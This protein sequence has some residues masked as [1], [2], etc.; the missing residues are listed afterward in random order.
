[1]EVLQ[2]N[3]APVFTS[4]APSDARIRE[5][6]R[7]EYQALALDLDGDTITYEIIPNEAKP[8]TPTTATI[9]AATGL[10]SWTPA[11]S[12]VGGAF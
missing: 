11:D 6:K 12:E 5:T 9:D 2:G 1:M 3:L 4:I 7:F 10:V 8:I